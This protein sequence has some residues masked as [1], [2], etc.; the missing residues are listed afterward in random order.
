MQS[1]FDQYSGLKVALFTGR[2]VNNFSSSRVSGGRFGFCVFNPK[3]AKSPNLDSVSSYKALAHGLEEGI[4]NFVGELFFYPE[5]FRYSE[6]QILLCCRRHCILP[7]F[8]L[9][10]LLYNID[11]NRVMMQ[12][13]NLLGVTQNFDALFGRS[14]PS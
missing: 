5:R 1:L 13:K 6:R 10:K 12:E 7:I 11:I 9:N 3:N 2:D 8:W 4:H 14:G